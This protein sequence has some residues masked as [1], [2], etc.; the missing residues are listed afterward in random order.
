M[1]TTQARGIDPFQ[2]KAAHLEDDALD[3]HLQVPPRALC[4]E[5]RGAWSVLLT[6][7]ITG[8]IIVVTVSNTSIHPDP[9]LPPGVR[10]GHGLKLYF[11]LTCMPQ[12]LNPNPTHPC[13]PR[14]KPKTPTP[15]L[16]QASPCTQPR[17]L[18]CRSARAP[19]T[20]SARHAAP[21][22]GPPS[23]AGSRAVYCR[24][25]EEERRSS[26]PPVQMIAAVQP[27]PKMLFH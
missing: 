20:G 15:I 5:W 18:P 1:W 4:R 10:K 6:C 23:D 2:S 8:T 14:P 26:S 17:I 7:V 25:E 12:T 27:S 16:T 24:E 3:G 11:T 9:R 19:P 13:L 22:S 21:P